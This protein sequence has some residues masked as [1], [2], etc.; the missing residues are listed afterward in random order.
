MRYLGVVAIAAGLL[1]W[2][3]VL[4]GPV[5]RVAA[6]RVH[7]QNENWALMRVYSVTGDI[8]SRVGQV[9]FNEEAVFEVRPD[10]AGLCTVEVRAFASEESWRS[11]PVVC[12]PGD[13][14][15]LVV[16]P[17]LSTTMLVPQR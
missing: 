4:A 9:D 11:E 5:P 10:A 7:V 15:Q 14:L 16:Q 12:Q 1:A 13:L 8:P 6:V 17:L 2:A 3:C